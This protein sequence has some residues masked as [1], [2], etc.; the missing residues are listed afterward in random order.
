[1]P[2]MLLQDFTAQQ[3]ADRIKFLASLKK[4]PPA[5]V[6]EATDFDPLAAPR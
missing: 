6:K 1:M 2:E 5:P 3:A 4:T